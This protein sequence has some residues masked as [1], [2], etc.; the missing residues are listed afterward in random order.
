MVVAVLVLLSPRFPYLE[1][2]ASS[3]GTLLASSSM[4]NKD[5]GRDRRSFSRNQDATVSGCSATQFCL[6]VSGTEQSA[7]AKGPR[8]TGCYRLPSLIST[9]SAAE[10]FRSRCGSVRK[11]PVCSS[12]ASSGAAPQV[13]QATES[14]CFRVRSLVFTAVLCN[15]P[16]W[17]NAQYCS[18]STH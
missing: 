11:A 18:F 12:Q 3:D 7:C 15:D 13:G 10:S 14:I 4:F 16:S 6:P 9:A 17:K 5:H 1:N 8:P 2:P